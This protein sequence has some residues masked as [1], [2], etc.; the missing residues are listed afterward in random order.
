MRRVDAAVLAELLAAESRLRYSVETEPG[1]RPYL[2]AW[3]TAGPV[4]A[5]GFAVESD[6]LD[7]T[8]VV[9]PLTCERLDIVDLLAA[10]ATVP[11]AADLAGVRVHTAD[12]LIRYE[13]HRAGFVSD[14]RGPLVPGDRP[15]G[16]YGGLLDR[17]DGDGERDAGWLAGEVGRVVTGASVTADRAPRAFGRLARGA[18]AGFGDMARLVV[19]PAGGAPAFVVAVPIRDDVIAE[20]VALAIDTTL[21]V[22]RTFGGAIDHLKTVSFDHAAHGMVKGRYAGMANANAS[23]VHINASFALADD[24]LDLRRGR[25]AS[26]P[27]RPSGQVGGPFTAIDGTTA[28]ELWHQMEAAFE[29]RHYADS[30]QFRRALGEYFGVETIEQVTNGGHARSPDAWRAAYARLGEEVS[31]YA[32]TNPRE[33]TAEMFKFWWCIAGP[34]P[35]VIRQF[36]ALLETYF[37]VDPQPPADRAA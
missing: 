35:P 5:L 33:A 34:L 17:R 25:E 10:L 20:S 4:G 2:R 15:I 37:G 1:A 31:P 29:A 24:L 9:E 19:R 13:A 22:R 36:G 18:T 6:V 27:K 16:P 11:A 26:P 32:T 8:M 30:I 28:H 21:A 3:G 14:L 12:L 23:V 7:V